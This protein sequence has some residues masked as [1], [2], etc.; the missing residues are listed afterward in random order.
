MRERERER[1]RAREREGVYKSGWEGHESTEKHGE[2]S[3]VGRYHSDAVQLMQLMS[4]GL[5]LAVSPC[6][7]LPTR[8][9]VC[10]YHCICVCSFHL[11]TTV[12]SMI[13]S[14]IRFNPSIQAHLRP[15]QAVR[16]GRRMPNAVVHGLRSWVVATCFPAPC[17]M[18]APRWHC[19]CRRRCSRRNAGLFLS[20]TFDTMQCVFQFT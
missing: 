4:G 14:C 20:E 19:H 13:V 2:G 6:T 3:L 15:V 8:V 16:R 10:I 17:T 7:C 1:E 5:M 9:P 11:T 18:R 12:A